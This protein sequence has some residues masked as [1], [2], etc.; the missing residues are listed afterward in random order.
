MNKVL[1]F[2]IAGVAALGLFVSVAGARETPRPRAP[3]MDQG[4]VKWWRCSCTG[5]GYTNQA[6]CQA[7]CA[8]VCIFSEP[9]SPV[10]GCVKAQ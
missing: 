8:G 4:F 9:G 5:T 10:P 3:T 2:A 7:N 1:A 6:K